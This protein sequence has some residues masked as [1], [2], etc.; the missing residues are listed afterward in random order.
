[1]SASQK[2]FKQ[3]MRSE[4]AKDTTELFCDLCVSFLCGLSVNL[5][6]TTDCRDMQP[7]PSNSSEIKLYLTAPT[8]RNGNKST[9]LISLKTNSSVNP[10]ILNG[11]R[12]NQS[13]GRKTIMSNANGQHNTN[14][15]HH[16]KIAITVFI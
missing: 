11:S 15:K 9:P 7:H 1:M 5:S 13:R 4:S 10:K 16:S 8:S 3:R 2:Y 12:S 6:L 14:K